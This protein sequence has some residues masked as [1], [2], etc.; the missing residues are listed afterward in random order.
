MATYNW[1]R[2]FFK[3]ELHEESALSAPARG[4]FGGLKKLMFCINGPVKN[5]PAWIARRLSFRDKRTVV[6]AIEEILDL[7]LLIVSDA[8]LIHPELMKEIENHSAARAES[9]MRGGRGNKA[10]QDPSEEQTED[11]FV[12]DGDLMPISYETGGSQPIEKQQNTEKLFKEQNQ[13]KK[14]HPPTPAKVIGFAN[15]PGDDDS[16]ISRIIVEFDR[17]LDECFGEDGRRSRRAKSD[18]ENAGKWLNAANGSVEIVIDALGDEMIRVSNKGGEIPVSL[19]F[20]CD[21]M[22]KEIRKYQNASTLTAA[23]LKRNGRG[24]SNGTTSTTSSSGT[25][26]WPKV[27]RDAIVSKEMMI[28]DRIKALVAKNDIATANDFARSMEAI[29]SGKKARAA[30]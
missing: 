13:S 16:D 10:A 12:S 17:L 7:G 15:V 18:V 29:A 14:D 19:G 9:G 20:F 23:D 3:D 28:V 21:S 11:S 1:Y 8:G 22:P 25:D 30:A 2:C 27:L 5:D 26:I 6:K 24:R 4:V